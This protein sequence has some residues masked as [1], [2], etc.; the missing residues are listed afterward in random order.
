MIFWIILTIVFFV[1]IFGSAALDEEV[2]AFTGT[3]SI[4]MFITS[5]FITIACYSVAKENKVLYND[6]AKN[7]QC[8]SINDL[9]EA[10]KDIQCHKAHQ[11]HWTSFYNGYDFPEINVYVMDEVDQT[12]HIV[13]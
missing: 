2:A 1:L 7:P 5:F 11:G 4:L 10:H 8:Y 3:A 9:K 6:M 13:E 12:L